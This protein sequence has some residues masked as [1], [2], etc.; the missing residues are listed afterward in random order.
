M[1]IRL[2]IASLFITLGLL[3]GCDGAD[4][5]DDELPQNAT[6]RI[7]VGSN[8]RG[9]ET[10]DAC[11]TPATVRIGIGGTV[12]WHN[13]DMGAHTVTSGTPEEGSGEMF[14]SSL[15]LG[16][17]TFEHRFDETGTFSYFCMLHPWQTGTVIAEE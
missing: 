14:D 10:T 3:M 5:M 6:V 9:C 7:P 13:D 4:S 8:V 2:W 11:Y 16:G 12:T 15:L 17:A 1:P